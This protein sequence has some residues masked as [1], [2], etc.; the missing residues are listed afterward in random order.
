[1]RWSVCVG[2]W[3]AVETRPRIG[4]L[5]W[6]GNAACGIEEGLECEGDEENRSLVLSR[7]G[8]ESGDAGSTRDRGWGALSPESHE[9]SP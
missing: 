6:I 8:C 1:M 9:D 2:L 5:G 7:S 3:D 4:W